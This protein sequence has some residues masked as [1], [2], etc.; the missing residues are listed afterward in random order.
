MLGAHPGRCCRGRRGSG[1]R[2]RGSALHAA[3]DWPRPGGWR[4]RAARGSHPRTPPPADRTTATYFPRLRGGHDAQRSGRAAV[5]QRGQCHGAPGTQARHVARGRRRRGPRATCR[6]STPARDASLPAG[7]R[8]RCPNGPNG[9]LDRRRVARRSPQNRLHA[10]AQSPCA[11]NAAD[12][13]RDRRSEG[14]GRRG[15]R[16]SDRL[17]GRRGQRR[18]RCADTS[19]CPAAW[20]AD[21]PIDQRRLRRPRGG[22]DRGAA[23]QARR[24][25]T[26]GDP[27]HQPAARGLRTPAAATTR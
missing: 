3:G 27:R 18:R 6:R 13:G 1:G 7:R 22:A 26:R 25:R 16:G 12:H 24:T 4:R 14:V 19:S 2:A 10:P 8:W 9:P 15:E 23:A 20:R 21:H 5:H 17:P 11:S